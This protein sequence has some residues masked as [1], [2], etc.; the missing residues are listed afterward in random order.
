M[1][2]ELELSSEGGTLAE[3]Y[4]SVVSTIKTDTSNQ[5]LNWRNG[6]RRGDLVV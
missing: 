2:M 1:N 6:V 3:N 4:N 5:I